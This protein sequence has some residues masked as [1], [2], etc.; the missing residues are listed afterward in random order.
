MI[1]K[2]I[3]TS[4][5]CIVFV[6]GNSLAQ[7]KQS[8]DTSRQFLLTAAREIMLSA[9][10]CG[11]ITQDEQGI[12]QV[13]TMDP[14]APEDDFTV[15]LATHPNTRKVQQIKNNPKI[16]LYYPDKNDKGYV[17]IHGVAELVN[18]QKEKDTRWKSEWKNFYANRTDAYLLIKVKPRY[19]ELINYNLGISGD[20]KTWQ[21]AVVRFEN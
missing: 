17:T 2:V 6:S 5:L 14:F 9:K 12:P 21:P 4:L 16:T 15:W 11:V 1:H 8:A 7:T 20:P 10:K 13:R 18:D 3:V 19:M